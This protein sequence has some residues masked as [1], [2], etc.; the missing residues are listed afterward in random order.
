LQIDRDVAITTRDGVTLRADVYRP[1]SA[2]RFPVLLPPLPYDNSLRR[3]P[4]V[5]R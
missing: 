1:D 2:G 4:I 3:L 5:P